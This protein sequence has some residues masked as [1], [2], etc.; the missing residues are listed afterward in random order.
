MPTA[1]RR[2]STRPTTAST[3]CC[4]TSRSAR[5][6]R[7]TTSRA[8]CA[9]GAT[10]CRSSC[11]PRSTARPTR[12]RASRRAPTTTSPSR[13]AS[14]SCAAASARS[15]AASAGACSTTATSSPS[16]R[17]SSTAAAARSPAAASRSG[18]TFSEFELL[19][20]PALRA[21]AAVQP[22]GAAARDLG[23]QRLPRPA[24]DRRPH[25]PPAREARG[26]PGGAGDDPHRPR[27]GVPLPGDV[28]SMR[29]RPAPPAAR[30]AGRSPRRSRSG[31]AAI[32]LL[33]PLQDRL[34]EDA[35]DNL[36]AAVLASRPG[37][38][39]ELRPAATSSSRARTRSAQRTDSRVQVYDRT[40]DDA[41]R[42]RDAR[43]RRPAPR[44][45][46]SSPRGGRC[47]DRDARR[48][49][50]VAVTLDGRGRA[51][52]RRCVARKPLTD[53]AATV[54]QVR[55]AFL[56][57][58]LIGLAVAL[59][60]GTG[61]EL[62]AAAPAR[63]AAPGRGRAT[64]RSRADDARDEVGDL[65]PRARVDAGEPA[66]ARRRRGARSSRPRRT[67]CARR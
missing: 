57:A 48:G 2:S 15:C 55:D 38:E 6:R 31:T 12:S 5:A 39:R 28:S 54:D 46:R 42:Q 17:S 40:P 13:S 29:V 61:L 23:R 26:E 41:L 44:S 66:A 45:T 7:A 43:R 32:A 59:L 50:R 56:T 25:P 37:I 21:R 4:S 67:S 52:R 9:R 16:G 14:P 47:D 30:R 58:A 34:R 1:S 49:R 60:L 53:V 11:S 22:P 19:V 10:S 35:S 18:S 63:A 8:S 64:R 20:V 62:D 36:R 51:G 27:R 33:G 24:R 3:S 65:D